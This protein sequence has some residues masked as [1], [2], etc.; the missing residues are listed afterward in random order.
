MGTPTEKDQ[1]NSLYFNPG[2]PAGFGGIN[3]LKATSGANRKT[4]EN[5]LPYQDAYTLHKPARRNYRRSQTKVSGIDDQWQADLV[6]M[7]TYQE[8]N[9]GYRYLLTIIDIFSKVA[10]VLPL[11]RKTGDELVQALSLVFKDGRQPTKLNTDQGTEFENRKVQTFLKKNH[12]HY[13][14][15]RSDK[16]AA[17]VERFNRTLKTKMWRY[18]THNNTY[19]YI[20]V[21]QDFVTAYNN[22]KHRSIGMTPNQVNYGNETQVYIKLFGYPTLPTNI[23]YKFN[24]GDSVHITKYKHVFDKGYLPNWTEEIFTI[25]Q[26]VPRSPPMYHLKDY[27]DDIIEGI[28]YEAE[29]QKVPKPAVML[30]MWLKKF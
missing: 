23:K 3:P 30:P 16:K 1:L 19:K 21:L 25:T 11:K 28:F 7:S 4:I 14:S 2:Q 8:F 13:F 15:T 26:Q 29:L 6:D 17:V 12:I 20:D 9:A 22:S 24:V 18:F 10:W 5:W 27:K